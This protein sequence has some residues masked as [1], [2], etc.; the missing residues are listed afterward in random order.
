M[1]GSVREARHIRL[2]DSI[3]LASLALGMMSPIAGA[4]L[5]KS[6]SCMDG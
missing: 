2:F 1:E 6:G 4:H 3:R 5:P